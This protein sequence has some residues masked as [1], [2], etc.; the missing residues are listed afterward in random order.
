MHVFQSGLPVYVYHQV[1]F[2]IH[3]FYEHFHNI[4]VSNWEK[5]I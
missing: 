2:H 5:N 1:P 3:A 4:Y